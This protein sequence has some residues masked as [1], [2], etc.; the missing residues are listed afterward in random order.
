MESENNS[1]KDLENTESTENIETTKTTEESETSKNTESTENSNN[2]FN[3]MVNSLFTANNL[4]IVMWFV[5]VYAVVYL[6][7]RVFK[8]KNGEEPSF[9]N[10]VKKIVD[11]LVVLLL[12]FMLIT[13]FY[14]MSKDDQNNTTKETKDYIVN[15]LDN[16]YSIVPIIAILAGFYLFLF[17]ARIPRDDNKPFTVSF[18]EGVLWVSLVIIV[19][20][21]FFKQVFNMSILEFASEVSALETPEETAANTEN[22]TAS[23]AAPVSA[24]TAETSTP[25]TPGE[26]TDSC[27]NNLTPDQVDPNSEVFHV[28]NNKYTYQDAQAICKSYGATLATYKQVEDAYTKGGE[29]CGYGWSADQMALFPTQQSTFDKLKKVDDESGCDAKKSGN[30]VQF[31]CGRPGVNGG[32]IANPYVKFGVNCFGKKPEGT[33]DQLLQMKITDDNFPKTPYQ[34]ELDAKVDFWKN[35]KTGTLDVKSF[36]KERWNQ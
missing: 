13:F 5:G 29:W 25:A 32:Y 27:A 8:N 16:P 12:I 23:T 15:F 21:Q 20:V 34:K 2:D 9:Q 26:S 36:N 28:G 1:T 35:S 3:N 11:F 7:L 31:N 19:I 33:E 4:T 18:I 24:E 14:V 6:G 10:S 22:S 17:L 30:S